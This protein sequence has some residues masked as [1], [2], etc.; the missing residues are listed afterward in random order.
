MVARRA[1][2]DRDARTVA[3]IVEP[4]D[5][6]A[7]AG[8]ARLAV[9]GARLPTLP[10]VAHAGSQIDALAVA[11]G[12]SCQATTSA[13]RT[14]L[15]DVAIV[16]APA[17]VVHVCGQIAALTTTECLWLGARAGAARAR[18][19]RATLLASRRF[20]DLT[21]T[22]VVEAVANLGGP[23]MDP[24]GAVIA[25]VTAADNRRMA[26]AVAVENVRHTDARPRITPFIRSTR[27]GVVAVR[28]RSANPAC[29]TSRL[30]VAR[31]SGTTPGGDRRM[32]ATSGA[33]GVLGAIDLVVALGCGRAYVESAAAASSARAPTTSA[34]SS[35]AGQNKCYQH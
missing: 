4:G 25:V 21:V 15:T 28:V 5:A 23:R 13:G 30:E 7:S 26:I 32:D 10:A 24:S 16:A 35:A 31:L 22:V 11:E 34:T 2:S 17:A 19:T 20:I 12:F 3:T 33:A 18:C 9:Q 1:G 29:L 6:N 27:V 14:D 8:N